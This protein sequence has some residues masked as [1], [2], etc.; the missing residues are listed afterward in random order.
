[1]V[2]FVICACLVLLVG[3]GW[4]P[5]QSLQEDLRNHTVL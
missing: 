3:V 5:R 4:Q 2:A 1:M